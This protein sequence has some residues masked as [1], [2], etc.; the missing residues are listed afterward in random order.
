MIREWRK[1][2]EELSEVGNKTKHTLHKVPPKW[3]QLEKDL[4][5]WIIEHRNLGVAVNTKMVILEARKLATSM[6]VDDFKGT[7]AFFSLKISLQY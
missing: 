7:T 1:Q 3:L 5:A 2:E 4:C 6:G